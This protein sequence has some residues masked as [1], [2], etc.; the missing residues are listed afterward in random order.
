MKKI[1]IDLGTTNTVVFIPKK[2]IIINEPSV[3]AISILDNKI[4]SVGNLAKEMIGRTPDSIIV[5]KPLIDGAIADYRVTGAMLRYF[6]K[7]AGGFLSFVKPE[8]LISVPAG[9]NSTEKRAVIEAALNAGAKAVYLVKEPVLAAIGAKIS[10][11]SPAGN[12]ILNIGGG[13][14]EIAVISLGGIVTW[15]SVRIGGNKL[16]QAIVEYIKKKHGLAI[17]E[18]TAELL[19]ISI[20]SAMKVPEEEKINIR[21]RDLATG[22]PKTIEITTNEITEAITEQLREIVQIIKSVLEITP[23]ELC[24]DIMDK[25]IHI[26]GG[27]ALLKNIDKLITKVTG[28]PATI[29]D[30]PLFCVARGTGIVLENL[31]IYKRNVLAKR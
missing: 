15:K 19:K 21:G 14:T 26:S 3:V 30:D 7:R 22:Y 29:A 17:G 13:T 8:V 27:G 10:I 11:N 4:M 31:D 23:P 18:R 25:G 16:D 2:G 9:I 5:S 6:I 20:G 1:G 28:V 12:M 24:S